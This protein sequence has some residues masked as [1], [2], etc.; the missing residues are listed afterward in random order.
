MKNS[1]KF[2]I[3]LLLVF[4]LILA[5]MPTASAVSHP[6]ITVTSSHPAVTTLKV[7]DVITFTATEATSRT[8]MV[9][10]SNTYNGVNL[11]TWADQADG[12]YTATY[13]VVE[14]H[15]DI[16]VTQVT[17][18]VV[19]DLADA[20]DPSAPVDGTG[21]SAGIDANTPTLV[22][23]SNA[24]AAG[25]LKVGDTII[26][27][28]TPGATELGGSVTGSYN[29]AALTWST[30]DGGVTFTAT[31]TVVEGEADQGA[32]LQIGGVVITDAAANVAAGAAGSD[33]VK[34]IDA[35]TP[36]LVVTSNAGD[37]GV[38]K[39][40]DTVIFTGTPGATE[41]GGSVTG[42]YNGA[43]LTWSTADGGVTFTAT[44]TVVEGEADQGVALQI[45]G[46]VITDA[47]VNVAAGAVGSD[48]VK[49]ID[50]N[51][52]TVTVEQ[53]GGQAD[54]TSTRPISYD[55][56]FSEAVTGFTKADLTFTGT[57]PG[58]IS[59]TI[60]GAGPAYVVTVNGMTHDGTASFDVAA[61]STIDAGGN[62]NSIST[63]ADNVVTYTA[64]SG[65]GGSYSPSASSSG[66]GTM[67]S[68]W[69][70]RVPAGTTYEASDFIAEFYS[71]GSLV[72]AT[73]YKYDQTPADE[74]GFMPPGFSFDLDV[75]LDGVTAALVT[76]RV[77]VEALP[78]DG[79]IKLLH[80][81]DGE[82]V[83]VPVDI[84]FQGEDVL[85]VL[86]AFAL[87]SFSPFVVTADEVAVPEISEDS[88]TE[89]S[90]SSDQPASST[91]DTPG[92]TMLAAAAALGAA[93]V[94]VRRRL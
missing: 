31:Y 34:T 87:G 66:A 28:G 63:S 7:A 20:I 78:T 42:S 49:T 53:Q 4:G 15:P 18:V 68:P 65:G 92:P 93:L 55:V 33:V 10:T 48:V 85:I 89:S 8:G 6:T 69:I 76:I 24:G 25:F 41:L 61:A 77:P 71:E 60:S 94:L 51:S 26:F 46:V 44:Y 9:V 35:N 62:A 45:G 16:G 17:N 67:A 21:V 79:N 27:T 70:I 3:G 40:G 39:V 47:A 82:Y 52:P 36:T 14:G 74:F 13:T 73:A 75:T 59:F 30:A 32:A 37:V 86:D 1:I 90:S 38:L 50:A 84:Y 23:T 81:V 64:P 29:G 58:S 22:V 43:A 56:T 83:E 5:A 88:E 57:A 19:D 2:T 54:P 72:T 91:K 12:T 80:L 11:G